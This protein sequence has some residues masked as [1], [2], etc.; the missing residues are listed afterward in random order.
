[1]ALMEK[2]QITA[3]CNIRSYSSWKEFFPQMIQAA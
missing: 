1:M 2:I 3:V